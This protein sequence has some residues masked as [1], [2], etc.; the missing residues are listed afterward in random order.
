MPSAHCLSNTTVSI[1]VSD[2]SLYF[3]LDQQ[4]EE[5]PKT[6]KKLKVFEFFVDWSIIDAKLISVTSTYVT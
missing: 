5:D 4:Q 3:Y 6:I 1:N 2:T